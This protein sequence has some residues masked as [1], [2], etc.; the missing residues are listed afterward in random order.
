MK[1]ATRAAGLG[2]IV[3]AGFALA[4]L[5]A[6]AE[7][8]LRR[9]WIH[10]DTPWAV[11]SE[12][13]TMG[14]DMH[15]CGQAVQRKVIEVYASAEQ[16]DDLA[17][18]G[19]APQVIEIGRPFNEIQAAAADDPE[20]PTG[21][22]DLAAVLQRMQDLARANSRTCA[23]VDL[24][25]TYG[26]PPTAQGRHLYA[27]KISDNAS[28]DEGE[29]AVL[30]AACHHAREITTP[31]IALEAAERLLA[32]YGSDP[33]ITQAINEREIW[34]APVWNPDGYNHVCTQDSFWRKNRRN[35]GNGSFG[36]DL[37][38]NYPFG[39]GQC[40]GSTSTSSDIYQGP[41]AGS[42]PETQTMLA[43][44]DDRRFAIVGDFHSYASEVRYGYG[45]W[46]H[47]WDNHFRTIA[48]ELSVSSGYFGDTGSSCCLGG[49]IHAH[50]AETGALTFLW[51]TGTSFQPSFA[52]GQAEAVKVWPGI[53]D[54]VTRDLHI[55]GRVTGQGGQPVDAD[56]ELV[57]VGFQHDEQ[58]GSSARTGL[59][60]A[61]PPAGMYTVRFTAEGYLPREESVAYTGNAVVLDVAMTQEC[62]AD[63]AA[64]FGQLTFADISAFLAAFASQSPPADLAAPVGSFTFADIT[65]FL[66]AFNAGCP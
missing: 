30:V 20:V 45:C 5:Q 43:F 53:L 44:R 17:R 39:W 6:G 8:P 16:V 29:P 18:A 25:A 66:G 36:V 26:T 50:A 7:E 62:P 57:G 42:E 31:L 54:L 58:H 27:L 28:M 15:G 37:N 2:L 32:G 41:S 59:Y 24:T 56:I 46:F 51:E 12:L 34:I 14:F 22:P 11:A 61:F 65:A 33:I 23:F 38:R 55:S 49:D 3:T 19:Y 10:S 1:N 40:G 47:P 35:N 48:Q 60:H 52:A 21:Y 63:L 9:V 64:P 4:T 13:E